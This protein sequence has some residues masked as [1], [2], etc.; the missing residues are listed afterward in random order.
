MYMNERCEYPLDPRRET[1]DL[2]VDN[3]GGHNASQELKC[4]L[5]KTQTT[6]HYFPPCATDLLKPAYSFV[7]L[8]ILTSGPVAGI[9]CNSS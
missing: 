9:I 8:N 2:W 7:F 5:D 1:L 3:C 6:M 4:A